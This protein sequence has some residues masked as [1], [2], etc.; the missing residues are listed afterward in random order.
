MSS[1]V[2]IDPRRCEGR[3]ACVAACPEGVLALRVVSR[4]LP[5][6]VKWRVALHGGH[7][8]VVANPAACTGC[9]ACVDAC[10]EQAITVE[11]E[12]AREPTNSRCSGGDE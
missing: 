9:G 3:R 8:A 6:L 1:R 11:A 2:T 10:P 4:E 12:E 5:L 7:Q